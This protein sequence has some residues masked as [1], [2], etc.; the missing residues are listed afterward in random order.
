MVTLHISWTKLAATVLELFLAVGS[1]ARAFDELLGRALNTQIPS[2]IRKGAASI[3]RAG[4]V[5]LRMAGIGRVA[6]GML[7]TIVVIAFFVITSN[8][9]L[10]GGTVHINLGLAGPLG[11]IPVLT[12]EYATL[13]QCRYRRSSPP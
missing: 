8:L 11:A 5:A 10:F 6:F 9:E 1:L 13:Q 2:W 4:T 12:S 7:I 3:G